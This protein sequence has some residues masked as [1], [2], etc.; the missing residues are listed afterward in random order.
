MRCK[1]LTELDN[2]NDDVPKY[3]VDSQEHFFNFGLD[4]F[5]PTGMVS[6]V[7]GKQFKLPSKKSYHVSKPFIHYHRFAVLLIYEFMI[8]MHFIKI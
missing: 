2:V 3:E 4:P 5:Y 6:Y 1:P 7:N 8:F